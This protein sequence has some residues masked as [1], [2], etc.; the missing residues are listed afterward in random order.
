MGKKLSEMTPLEREHRRVQLRDAGRRYLANLTPEEREARREK[1]RRWRAANKERLAA[2]RAKLRTVRPGRHFRRTVPRTTA[3]R[4]R[5]MTWRK[6][7]AGQFGE[8]TEACSEH[9]RWLDLIDAWRLAE[10]L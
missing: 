5:A 2:K 9:D 1:E 6:L 3:E 7:G 4:V 8:Y 10:K